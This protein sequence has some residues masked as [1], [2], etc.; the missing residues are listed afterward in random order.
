MRPGWAV[1]SVARDAQRGFCVAGSAAVLA[2]LLLS[3]CAA[4]Y[5]PV[6]GG[7][8]DETQIEADRA[9]C[10]A[11]AKQHDP[12]ADTALSFLGGA[13]WGAAEGVGIGLIHSGIGTG[14]GAAVG[15]GV[16]AVAGLIYGIA[17]GNQ[18]VEEAMTRCMRGRG[19]EIH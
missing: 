19:Y 2:A 6:S 3:G 7:A 5:V 17:A 11:E 14:E 15:A 9:A 12:L 4:N 8:V 18:D 13:A 1:S 16:G 10:E